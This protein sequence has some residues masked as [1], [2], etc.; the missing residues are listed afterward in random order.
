[1]QGHLPWLSTCAEGNSVILRRHMIQATVAVIVVLVLVDGFQLRYAVWGLAAQY[2]HWRLLRSYP[3]LT[4][5]RLELLLAL[6]LMVA[7]QVAWAL[8][9]SG[10]LRE[11]SQQQPPQPLD[12]PVRCSTDYRPLGAEEF[13][14]HDPS[15]Q[16]PIDQSQRERLEAACERLDCN[17]GDTNGRSFRWPWWFDAL[18]CFIT[19]WAVPFAF[20]LTLAAT[21]AILP[22]SHLPPGYHLSDVSLRSRQ[23]SKYGIPPDLDDGYVSQDLSR[24]MLTQ[25][26]R[27]H[28][29][30]KAA[31]GKPHVH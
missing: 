3:Y 1:M 26:S 21:D 25:K 17:A 16:S 7:N 29:V 15:R 6:L 10:K 9:L 18:F 19:V 5:Q 30:L 12:C 22:G 14:R 28:A 27:M 13:I 23:R 8:H 4:S 24:D 11:F 20:I 31:F 2:V